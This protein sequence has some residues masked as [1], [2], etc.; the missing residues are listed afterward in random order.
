MNDQINI[1]EISHLP[2]QEQAEAIAEKFSSI[3]NQYDPLNS[4]DISVPTFSEK[5]VPQFHPSQVWLLLT[6]LKTNK[7]TVPGDFPAKLIKMFAAYIAEPL[8]DIVNTSVRRGEYPKIY[9]FEICTPVPKSYPPKSTSEMRNISG[10]LT[11]DKIMEK[12][13]SEL[14]ISDMRLHLD[15]SQYGNQKGIS[16][17]HYL[18]DMIHRI[19]SALDNNSKGDTFAVVANLI[20][21]NNAFPRQCPKLGIESFIQN[22]VRPSLIPVLI[23][24]FQDREMSVKWH[25]C[26]SLPRTVT[27][28]GPQ[29]ATLGFLEYLSQ[30]N[31]SADCVNESDRF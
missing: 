20:D 17:Q 25:G 16:I 6:Q 21:W 19:V 10:L 31:N 3:P 30:L 29:G 7:A 27:R 11:F 13:I 22:G 1:D 9:K 15:P 26:R 4:D 23:N 18:I 2:N 12:L 14:I 28:G 24:Y 8:T 5:D